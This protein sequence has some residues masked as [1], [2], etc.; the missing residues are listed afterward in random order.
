[1]DSRSVGRGRK[2]NP[3]QHPDFY[4]RFYGWLMLLDS[5]HLRVSC[6]AAGMLTEMMAMTLQTTSGLTQIQHNEKILV[7]LVPGERSTFVKFIQVVKD[8]GYADKADELREHLS[9][10]DGVVFSVQ[11]TRAAQSEGEII[12]EQDR[13]SPPKVHP[14]EPAMT[15]RVETIARTTAQP[16]FTSA[17]STM[18]TESTATSDMR[19]QPMASCPRQKSR[20]E[21]SSD[22]APAASS[23]ANLPKRDRPISEIK[24]VYEFG[25]EVAKF[26]DPKNCDD[27]ARNLVI[28]KGEPV[29]NYASI[30][31]RYI[32]RHSLHDEDLSNVAGQ[33]FYYRDQKP[34]PSCAKF[35]AILE[36]VS[37]AVVSRVEDL[38]ERT[39][40]SS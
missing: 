3:W 22:E 29:D 9:R 11:E 36:K 6:T 28:A 34:V 13:Q 12:P 40:F 30:V 31:L 32:R 8:L 14:M 2:T 4:K 19:G 16:E 33:I 17:T 38:L 10:C 39:E 18:V 25:D 35:L 26:F 21:T 27:L 23:T 37:P 5:A 7:F 24:D 15:V 1:M 20:L